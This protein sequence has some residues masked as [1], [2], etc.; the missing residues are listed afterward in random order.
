MKKKIFGALTVI[1]PLLIVFGAYFSMPSSI[2][3][4]ENAEYNAYPNNFVRL[5][6][7][8]TTADE[9]PQKAQLRLFGTVPIKTI[10]VDVVP[11]EYVI[12]GGRAIGV[13][14]Y[15]DGIMAVKT[16]NT[17]AAKIAG[18]KKGDV[19]EEINHE[20]AVS[21]E[22]FSKVVQRGKPM[23]L[24]V[25]RDNNSFYADVIPQKKKEG[26][27]SIGLWIRD[28]GAGI[29]TMSFQHPE[30]LRFGALG[31]AICDSDTGDV[32]PLLKGTVSSCRISAVKPGTPEETGEL[33]GSI[34][35]D[36][37]GEVDKNSESGLYGTL[38]E[39]IEGMLLPIAHRYQV[40]TGKAEILCDIN[41]EGVKSYSAEITGITSYEDKG[42][43]G[44]KIKITDKALIEAT[45][46]IVQGMS[47]SP[48]VQNGK[49]VG[50]VTHVFVNDPTRGYGIFIENMLAEAGKVK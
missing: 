42:N 15:S 23:V 6:S 37:M 4:S 32:I 48:I 5:V 2:T 24:T 35:S 17:G 1:L 3:I 44:L 21:T 14:L 16:E 11:E 30:T 40:K 33:V 28:S 34:G 50:A 13:R 39:R 26:G 27:Y 19:I 7:E 25:K 18:I 9:L 41:G 22:Q 43:K 46:G 38:S 49:L 29:G 12:V 47:G 10:D 8:N 45:G 31:H 20:K 36:V